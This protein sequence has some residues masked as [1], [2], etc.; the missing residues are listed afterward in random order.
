MKIQVVPYNPNWPQMFEVESKKIKNA[1]GNNCIAIHHIG[2]T[3]VPSLSAKP[4]IDIIAV[5]RDLFFHESQL[6]AIEYRYRGGF[7]IPLQK[8]FTIRTGDRNINL[9][10]FEENDPE[11]ELNILFR[12]YLHHNNSA[13]E[14]YAALKYHLIE[15]EW[16]HQ[17][18]N[19]IYSRYTLG[20]NSFIQIILR[21]IGFN[22]HRFVFCTHYNEWENYHR[23]RKEQIFDPINIE[24]DINHPSLTAQEHFH[25]ALY[26][27]TKIVTVAHIEF[28]NEIE[29][30][31]R[32]L[33]TDEIYQNNGFGKIM[34]NF[35]EKWVQLKGKKILKMHSRLSAESFYRKLGYFDIIF[36]D[37][38]IQEN[39]INLGKSL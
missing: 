23:I 38:C 9:H 16:S 6:E 20:K 7:N 5:V 37:P 11:I 27:G 18:N 2:S 19:S 33:A 29:A 10:I 30:A 17:K 39:Y 4:Q 13:R 32:S 12:D 36:E 21:E 34:M 24:Y 25:F 35:L 28:L 31:L 15:K 26:Q 14:E 3:S 1:L 22:K 8:C